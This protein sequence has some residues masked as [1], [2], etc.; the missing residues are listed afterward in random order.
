[1][2]R[3][4]RETITD[5]AA[6]RSTSGYSSSRASAVCCFESFSRLSARRSDSVRRS[7]SNSTAAATSGPASDPR[8]ASSAPAT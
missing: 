2:P 6:A 1:M 8:P 7:R 3:T 4:Q 5:R